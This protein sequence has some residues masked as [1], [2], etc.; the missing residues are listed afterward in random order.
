MPD[1]CPACRWYEVECVESPD[2]REWA[3]QQAQGVLALEGEANPRDRRE[4]D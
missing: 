3:A 2:P 1:W 4:E